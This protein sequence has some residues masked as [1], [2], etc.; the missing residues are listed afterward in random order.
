M[1]TKF[2]GGIALPPVSE[3]FLNTLDEAFTVPDIVP[4]YDRDTAMYQAGQRFVVD[5]IKK[6]SSS[7]AHSGDPLNAQRAIVRMGS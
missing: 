4:G 5:W 1:M 6:H 2:I 3:A 7:P